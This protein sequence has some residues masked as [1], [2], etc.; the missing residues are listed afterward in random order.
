MRRNVFTAKLFP[1][2]PVFL[3]GVV[4]VISAGCGPIRPAPVADRMPAPKAAPNVAAKPAQRAPAV[5]PEFYVVKP[6][7][8]LYSIATVFGI[9]VRDLAA[10][11]NIDTGRIQVGQQLRLTAPV[12]TT[13]IA[14]LKTVPGA[15]ESRPLEQAATSVPSDENVKSEPKGV[16]VPYSDQAYAQMAS[17]KPGPGAGP[18]AKAEPKQGAAAV[19]G[20]DWAWPATGKVITTFNNTTSK[21]ISISGRLGQPVVASAAGKVIF[22][23]TGIRGLGKFI[24]IKHSDAYISV[25]AHNSVL[26]VKNNQTV[27]KGQ[28]IAEMGNSDSDQVQLHFEIRRD[29]KPV[30]PVKLLPEPHA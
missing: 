6:G 30:D 17:I 11:N 1:C 16:R 2:R 28:K 20:I 5:R 3:C 29:G 24:V 9:E 27:V 13:V 10:W 12:S 22:S 14:P 25:Y 7:D 4:C 19:H 18:E 15:I 21:G 8:T 23:G 26:L